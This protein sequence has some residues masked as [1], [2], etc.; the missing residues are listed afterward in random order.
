MWVLRAERSTTSRGSCL[1]RRGTKKGR[2]RKTGPEYYS[3]TPWRSISCN[4]AESSDAGHGLEPTPR[5]GPN[6]P[7]CPPT[8]RLATCRPRWTGDPA[9]GSHRRDPR[10]AVV[11]VQKGWPEALRSSPIP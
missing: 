9:L 5:R 8:C 1:S 3:S 4:I 2:D 7:P 10:G 6:E 11:V